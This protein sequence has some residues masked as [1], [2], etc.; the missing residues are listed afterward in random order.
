MRGATALQS[1]VTDPKSL[2]FNFKWWMKKQGRYSEATMDLYC[3][4]LGVLVKRGVDLADPESIKDTIARQEWSASR[5]NNAAKAYTLLLSKYDLTWDKPKYKGPE[6]LPF[7]PNE[8]EIDSLIACCSKQ[9][10]AFLQTVK[11]TAGRR[12]EIF[13]LNWTDIDLLSNTIRITPEKGSNPRIIRISKK[14]ARILNSL[15][16]SAESEK[17]WIWKNA[18]YLDKQFRRQRRR[19][20]KKLENPRIW[21][22]HFHTLRHWKATM[23][24]HVTNGNVYYVM[25]FLGHKSIK[26]T[27]RYIHLWQALFPSN[28]EYT[29]EIASNLEEA[30]KLIQQGF[31]Y[32]TEMDDRKLFRKRETSLVGSSTIPEGSSAS[33]V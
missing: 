3:E 9:M 12:G 13:N 29:C 30:K 10:G 26:N 19:A 8:A 18:F 27:M 33:M 2:L 15:P 23:L 17:V 11:E 5:S 21:Q 22:I 24:C 32:V 14:L 7:I 6:K 31:E 16:R 4:V 25:K 28:E 1:D 20:T